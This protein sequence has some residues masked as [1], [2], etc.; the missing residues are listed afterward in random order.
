[1]PSNDNEKWLDVVRKKI[2]DYEELPPIDDWLAIEKSLPGNSHTKIRILW[3]RSSIIA[4]VALLLIGVTLFFPRDE[5]VVRTAQNSPRSQSLQSTS[6]SK[7]LDAQ[8]VSD[9]QLASAGSSSLSSPVISSRKV[10]C[11]SSVDVA[12]TVGTR[13]TAVVKS[14]NAKLL[15]V[16]D[17][18]STTA[19]HQSR[20][21]LNNSE[22]D[23][24]ASLDIHSHRSFTIFLNTGCS[25][26]QLYA[27]NKSITFMRMSGVVSHDAGGEYYSNE[28]IPVDYTHHL[29]IDIGIAVEKKISKTLGVAL[30]LTGIYMNSTCGMS[31][32][33]ERISQQV[34]YIGVP[35]KLNYYFYSQCKLSVYW[36]NGVEVDKCIY[37]K[38]GDAKLSTRNW[39]YSVGT[40]LG[41]QYRLNHRFSI[42]AEP[43]LRYYTTSG[44]SIE[45]Y[46]TQNPMSVDLHVG[47]KL[48]Y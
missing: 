11:L 41:F 22:Y 36:S 23:M 44:V 37:A 47:L 42:Y 34:Y 26:G 33:I 3:L 38:L 24:L 10:K 7:V 27:D 17:S 16:T 43:G 9:P 30:G 46:R 31:D 28:L 4:A 12:D 48:N 45:T 2:T 29:P 40:S 21:S 13:L 1:M 35:L 32:N 20:T 14:E 25:A 8:L 15:S 18:Q 19:N 6:S 5:A 39:Q